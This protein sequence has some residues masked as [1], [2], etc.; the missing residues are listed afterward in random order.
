MKM[1]DELSMWNDKKFGTDYIGKNIDY[2]TSKK[3][4]N[5]QENSTFKIGRKV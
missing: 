3:L 5:L 1:N 2:N 4:E